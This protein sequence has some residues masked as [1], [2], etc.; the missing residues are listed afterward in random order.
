MRSYVP[1]RPLF[2]RWTTDTK[3]LRSLRTAVV[4]MLI[5][6]CMGSL[7]S[8]EPQWIWGTEAANSE[9]IDGLCLFKKDFTLEKQP[10][11]GILQITCDD[12]YVVRLNG[13]L[14]GVDENWKDIEQ[15]DVSSVLKEGENSIFIQGRN[16]HRSRR[17][18]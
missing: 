14:V 8:A 3:L 6:A 17:D 5:A 10:T 4:P 9:A 2:S 1:S 13:R 18:R 15:Y 11:S 7:S 16:M 12:Q